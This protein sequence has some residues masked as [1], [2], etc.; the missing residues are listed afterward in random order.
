[1]TY[2]LKN[3]PQLLGT[4]TAFL[5]SQGRYLSHKSPLGA[6]RARN[7][8]QLISYEETGKITADELCT[9]TT[10]QQ[11]LNK[12]PRSPFKKLIISMPGLLRGL[13]M[14]SLAKSVPKGLNPWECEQTKLHEPP[15]VPYIPKKDK[16]QEEIAKLRN[17]QI[18]TLLEKDT[19]LNFPVWHENRTCGATSAGP[20][21][22]WFWWQPCFC[23]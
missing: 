2:K 9:R 8:V 12:T 10:F 4:G 11:F 1:M 14:M 7:A 23:R 15:P 21:W 19:M 6:S 18:K 17:L 5:S 16:V 20:V 22:L 3:N 13:H